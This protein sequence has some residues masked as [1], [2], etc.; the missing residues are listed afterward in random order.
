M[1]THSIR[2]L[3][4]LFDTEISSNE[5]PLFRGAM[6]HALADN[7]DAVFHDHYEDGTSRYVYPLVQYKRLA[8]CAAIVA[9]DNG[10]DHMGELLSR[11]PNSIQIGRRHAPL[12]IRRTIP[13]T[14]EVKFVGTPQRYHLS[15]WLPLNQENYEAYT[16]TDVLSEHIELLNNILCGN[17]LSML[18][19]LGIILDDDL[20][21]SLTKLSDPYT[22]HYKG[23]ARMAFDA[24]FTSNIT[25]PR[26]IGIGRNVSIGAGVIHPDNDNTQTE[27]Q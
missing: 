26:G 20:T 23:V 18:K 10:A 27:E 4:I 9:I 3:T 5:I 16:S 8:H 24:D 1:D 6:L 17:I 14:T 25:L 22:V 15:R 12:H 7:A 11:L 21:A 13:A 2:T 19:G